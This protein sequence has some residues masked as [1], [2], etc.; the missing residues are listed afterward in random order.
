MTLKRETRDRLTRCSTASLSSELLLDGYT[1][2]V[3][4]GLSPVASTHMVGTAFT[5]RYI[6][7]REDKRQSPV[8][9][10][11]RKDVQRI[12][13]E[14]VGSGQVLVVDA[15]GELGAA[16]FG[17]ILATRLMRRG[18]AGLVTDGAL[19]DYKAIAGLE[20]PVYARG[21]HAAT[22][23]VRHHAVEMNVPIACGGVAIFPGDVLVGDFDGVV[24]IPKAIA[25]DISKR[26]LARDEME[27]FLHEKIDS[28]ESIIDVYPP[29]RSVLAE[30]ERYRS[31]P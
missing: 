29:S 14:T 16:S 23:S 20:I 22:S 28:G 7:A 30:Y 2:V 15:R 6:P 5:L 25:D 12:A 19:R 11:N 13:V 31:E 1:N 27:E 26:A 8:D 17:Y 9:Y 4:E 18:A 10:D 24:V 3:L 21:A